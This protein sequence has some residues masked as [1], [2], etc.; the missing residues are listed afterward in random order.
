M[1]YAHCSGGSVSV[2]ELHQT[3]MHDVMVALLGY[4]HG[5]ST[6]LETFSQSLAAFRMSSNCCRLEGM[7]A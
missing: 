7:A 6:H 4:K 1:C 5:A 3:M 2:N